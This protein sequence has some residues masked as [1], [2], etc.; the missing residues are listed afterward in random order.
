VTV[1]FVDNFTDAEQMENHLNRPE[2]ADALK[3][4]FGEAVHLSKTLGTQTF[5]WAV[6]L[7]DGTVLRVSATTNSVFKSVLVFFPYVALITLMVI[8]LTMIIAN[9]LTKKIF[10]PL[11]NL[12]LEDPLSNDVYDELSPLLIR[13]AKQNDQIKSQFKKL[14]EQKEEFNAITENIREGIIVLNNKA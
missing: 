11:N 14:K 4:G 3:N 5:Y 7:N 10:L 2:I 6:R 12:N 9:L 13:M 1:L 8:L